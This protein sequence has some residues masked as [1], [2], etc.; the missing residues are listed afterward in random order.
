MI[1]LDLRERLQFSLSKA[2]YVWLIVSRFT[3]IKPNYN[4]YSWSLRRAF[5]IRKKKKIRDFVN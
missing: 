3:I 5:L 1:Q 4:N 2:S